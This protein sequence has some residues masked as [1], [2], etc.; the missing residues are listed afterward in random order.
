MALIGGKSQDKRPVFL[1]LFKI[2]L[3]RTALVSILHRITGVALVF[4]IPVLL[5]LFYAVASENQYLLKIISFYQNT[6]LFKF[7]VF[8]SVNI[9]LLHL[10]AGVRHMLDDFGGNH[11]L[12]KSRFT[13]DSVLVIF[14]IA[15]I[16]SFWRLYIYDI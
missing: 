1:N 13:A 6:L 12:S 11:S 3:P 7:I 4:L 5:V 14:F 15:L 9:P 2:H 16:F 8:L 10:L